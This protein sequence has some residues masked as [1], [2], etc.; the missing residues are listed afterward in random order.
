MTTQREKDLA[1]SPFDADD[2]RER[3]TDGA[4]YGRK[5]LAQWVLEVMRSQRFDYDDVFGR[6]EARCQ[7]V[8]K[9]GD[10]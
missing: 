10:A 8:L 4:E 3:W 7:A 1:A 5:D 6:I 9:G 2:Y